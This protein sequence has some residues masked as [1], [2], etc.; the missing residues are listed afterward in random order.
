M[1]ITEVNEESSVAFPLVVRHGHD[2][3][4]IVFLSAVLLLREVT[5]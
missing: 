3:A 4:D 1:V 2:T 5:D